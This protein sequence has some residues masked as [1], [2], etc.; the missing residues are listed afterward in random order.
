MAGIGIAIK[1]LGL[2]GK[3]KRGD[4]A[5]KN[6]KKD[7]EKLLIKFLKTKLVVKNRKKRS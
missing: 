4:F 2:L 6:F 5:M 7:F 1:G 3:K